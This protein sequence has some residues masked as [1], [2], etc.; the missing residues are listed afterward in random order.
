MHTNQNWSSLILLYNLNVH[1]WAGQWLSAHPQLAR[2]LL[3]AHSRKGSLFPPSSSARF[4]PTAPIVFIKATKGTCIQTSYFG[5][6][7]QTIFLRSTVSPRELLLRQT[8]S[9]PFI[10]NHSSHVL[11]NSCYCI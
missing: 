9:E 1:Y 10:I 4:Y 11:L 5:G 3:P 6:S 7:L 2:L 8:L